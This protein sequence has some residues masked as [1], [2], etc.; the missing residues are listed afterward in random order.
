MI[1]QLAKSVSAEVKVHISNRNRDVF[2]F[3]VKKDRDTARSK[4]SK[5][6]KR[7]KIPH[8]IKS[9]RYSGEKAICVEKVLGK[10]GVFIVFKTASGGMTETTLNSTITELLPC[11]AFLNK[12][13]SKNIDKF[14]QACAS[15]TNKSC[16]VARDE[17]DVGE[18]FINLMPDSS[19]FKEK[20]QNA[21]AITK[22]LNDLHASSPIHNVFWTYRKKPAGVDAK[23]PAD[24]VVQFKDKSLLGISLKAGD[25]TSKEPLLNSYVNPIM[26]QLST[27]RDKKRIRKMLF[28]GIYSTIP[29]IQKNYDENNMASATR[30]ILDELETRDIKQYEAKYDAMLELSRLNLMAVFTKDVNEFK[31]WA[32]KNILKE[33]DT[34]VI[35][36]KAV[37]NTTK[38]VFDTNI[39][40]TLIPQTRHISAEASKTSKQNFDIHL[41]N[42]KKKRIGTMEMSIRSNQVG[43]KHKLGQFFNLAVKYNGLNQP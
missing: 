1:E 16:Y 43:K 5:L 23:S 2:Y 41:F 4:V 36:I 7:N 29:G 35:I 26:S 18:N 15:A 19:K 11:L 42:S 39:L 40:G 33:T 10:D 30:N 37:G 32:R 3:K 24:I 34:P 27:D 17:I 22:Y 12:I 38:Q 13:K 31:K 21:I 6:L 28:E 9:T 20:V 14:Y 25:A 8:K